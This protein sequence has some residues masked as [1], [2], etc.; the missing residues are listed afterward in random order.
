VDHEGEN[1]SLRKMRTKGAPTTA[2]VK[3]RKGVTC[4]KRARPARR[5]NLFAEAR[6]ATHDQSGGPARPVA[7]RVLWPYASGSPT[8]PVALPVKAG[9]IGC[10]RQGCPCPH[11]AGLPD[12]AA[13]RK[14]YGGEAPTVGVRWIDDAPAL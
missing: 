1:T 12:S 10:L 9:I 5:G 7:P 8:R 13:R 14:G 3:I 6:R 4:H 2:M 11:G